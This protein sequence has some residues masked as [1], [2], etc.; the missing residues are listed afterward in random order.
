MSAARA[1]RWLLVC[2]AVVALAA[3]FARAGLPSPYLLAAFA[4][5]IAH[6]LLARP[7]LTVPGRAAVAAQGVIGV[8]AGSYLR[9]STV[10]SVGAHVVPI[11]AVSALTVALSVLAG[12]AL[13]RF[14][15][16]DRATA[17]F[18]MIAGGAA[19]IIA[20]SRELGA[21]ERL[22]AVMQYVR[23]L[24][25]VAVTP[26]VAIGVFGMSRAARGTA[27]GP[28]WS[29]PGVLY[30]AVV[31]AAGLALARLVRLPGGPIL[32][33]MLLA[34]AVSLVHRPLVAPVPV[35]VADAAIAAIGLDVG[36]RFTA[37][38]LR[39]AGQL[40]PRSIGVIA[41]MLFVSAGFGAGLAAAAHVSMLDGYLATTP[42]GLTA[43]IALTV[44]SDANTTF[45]VSVQVLRTFLMLAAAPSIARWLASGRRARP[46]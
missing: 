29:G 7:G 24:M 15:R 1:A 33:P 22:V 20:L 2:A 39:E 14:A 11:V 8:T 17:S 26:A 5:G 40:L 44:G 21:D 23:V 45:V 42:G 4:V 12:L 43:V 34:A 35:V 32:G 25:I 27:G 46:A 28:L 38:A 9:R 30:V 18:G 16:V 31:V 19:G 41:A 13:A 6:A 10:A 3:A 36:L 37:R